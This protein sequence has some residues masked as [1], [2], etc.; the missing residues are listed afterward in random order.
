MITSWLAPRTERIALIP[1]TTTTHTEPFHVA[2]GLQTLDH[3]SQGRAGWQLR[4]S[5]GAAEA[6]AFGRK[7]APAINFR[8][9]ASGVADTA[10]EALLDEAADS[11]E[12]SRRL[13]DSWEDNAIIRDVASG[14]FLDRELLHY[15][16]FKSDNFSVIGTSIVPRSPQGQ[17]PITVLAHSTPIYR[18]AA[19]VAD[20][21]FTTPHP[22]SSVRKLESVATAAEVAAQILEWSGEGIEGVRLRPLSNS[23]DLRVINEYC[24]SAKRFRCTE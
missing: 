17:I 15:I 14:R 19:R 20:V 2:T 16:D 5:A 7:G 9:V 18:L 22:L 10:L 23:K 6:A 1:T 21:V 4:I 11:A 13:W 24:R 3:I 8:N 12:V